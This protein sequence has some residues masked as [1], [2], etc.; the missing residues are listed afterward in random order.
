MRPSFSWIV[1][2]LAGIAA[3]TNPDTDD[4]TASSGTDALPQTYR[5][6]RFDDVVA[7]VRSE[8]AS[9]IAQGVS[10]AVLH[11]GEFVWVQAFGT[12]EPGADV[13]MRPDH[14]LQ[15]GST[16]KQMTA[17][18]AL[19]AADAGQFGLDDPVAEVLPEFSLDD[20]PGWSN[21]A[22]LH[23]LMSHQGG[24][25]DYID[26][27]NPADDEE[28]ANWMYGFFASNQWSMNPPGEFWNYS[29]PHFSL[30]GLAAEVHD[31]QGRTYAD[32]IEEQL[33]APLGLTDTYARKTHV[34]QTDRFALSTDGEGLIRMGG[35]PDPA[36][37]R[38]SGFVWSTPSDMCKWGDFLIH[39][40]TSVLSDAS[41]DLIGTPHVLT[42]YDGDHEA[43][44]YGQ[45][46]RDLYPLSDGY[47]PIEVW[48]HGGNT[49]SF[50]SVFVV[51]PEHD[52]VISI[53]SAGAAD[54]W[55]ETVEDILRATIEL[56]EPA[57]WEGPP[58]EPERLAGHVGTYVDPY[59]V[60]TIEITEGGQFGLQIAM[61]DLDALG[62]SVGPDLIPVSTDLWLVDLGGFRLDLSFV[63]DSSG[64]PDAES[65]YI[66]NRSFVGIRE[67]ATQPARATPARRPSLDLAPA[68]WE[69]EV[70]RRRTW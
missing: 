9:N 14:I 19:Q 45:F 59:N 57:A 70:R 28:L 64:G 47:Y 7:T 27:D 49:L 61:P 22:T 53:L 13:R 25:V 67:V 8:L 39:G 40:D 15:I 10:L 16:T 58:F 37:E 56:P 17:A 43:Y 24:L 35:V 33:F 42:G 21:V 34:R 2:A 31:P 29:N 6:A 60:G 46:V 63:R 23:D 36:P 41:R 26:P 66:R 5:D 1:V 68:F 3:C 48:E 52:T 65:T 51:V 18:L 20:D 50:T 32:L 62:Y 69:R 4:P 11:E 55:D 30:V 12:A 44:G 54:S 38:P